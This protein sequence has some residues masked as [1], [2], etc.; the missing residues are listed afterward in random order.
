MEGIPFPRGGKPADKVSE[1]RGP[2]SSDSQES[3]QKKKRNKEEAGAG[4]GSGGASEGNSRDL[5]NDEILFKVKKQRKVEGMNDLKNQ[6]KKNVNDEKNKKKRKREIKESVQN[7][8][9]NV[10]LGMIKTIGNNKIVK[11]DQL[12]YGKYIQGTTALG[13]ILQVTEESL[14]LSLP[15]GMIA[16]VPFGEISD[17]HHKHI[18]N[19]DGQVRD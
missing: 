4:G 16:I 6:K 10:G 11:I 13:Y 8:I 18:H 14:T 1:K 5:D 12:N 7:N 19:I 9:M 2:S 3:Q 17:I 15:G